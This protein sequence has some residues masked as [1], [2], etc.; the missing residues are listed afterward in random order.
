MEVRNCK[1]CG[2]MFNYLGSTTPQCPQCMKLMDDKYEGVKKYIYD[3]PGA[4]INDVSQDMDV[5]VKQIQRWVREE[6]L[7]FAENSMVG[8]EC[9]NCGI[10]IRT[11]RFCVSCKAKMAHEF[12][13]VLP[14]SEPAVKKEKEKESARMRFLN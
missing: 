13:N 12:N 2:R 8:I 14:R 9:E 10:M 4:S 11:G 3:N 6:R 1:G 7:T 5:S